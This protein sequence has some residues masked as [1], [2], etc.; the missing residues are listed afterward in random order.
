MALLKSL[1]TIASALQ[2]VGQCNFSPPN[3]NTS[4]GLLSS[5]VVENIPTTYQS[6]DLTRNEQKKI[7]KIMN[8]L[9]A[10]V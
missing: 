9:L 6:L 8:S 2:L 10:I 7:K 4:T 3:Q 5:T 1:E